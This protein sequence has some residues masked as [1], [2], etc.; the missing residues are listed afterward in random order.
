MPFLR[1]N[2][3]PGD[4]A[5]AASNAGILRKIFKRLH[6]KSRDD[7]YIRTMLQDLSQRNDPGVSKIKEHL[8]ALVAAPNFYE[9]WH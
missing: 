4:L 3:P 7:D 5:V 2:W 9:E 8:E 1:S 6:R